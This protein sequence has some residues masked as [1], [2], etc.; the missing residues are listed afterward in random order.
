MVPA[1]MIV[2]VTGMLLGSGTDLTGI[3]DDAE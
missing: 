2:I 1:T 3:L